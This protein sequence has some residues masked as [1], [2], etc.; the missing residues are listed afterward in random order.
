M[1]SV[2]L[3][4]LDTS[5]FPQGSQNVEESLGIPAGTWQLLGADYSAKLSSTLFNHLISVHKNQKVCIS[6]ID[7][8]LGGCVICV[9]PTLWAKV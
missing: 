3:R 1:L 5:T 2:D 8:F 6:S 7:Y 9:S 4:I